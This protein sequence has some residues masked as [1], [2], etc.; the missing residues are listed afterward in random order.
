MV[1]RKQ[2][3]FT[4]MLIFDDSK[5][6]SAIP[7]FEE[8]AGRNAI[9]T[10]SSLDERKLE[11]THFAPGVEPRTPSTVSGYI[12]CYNLLAYSCKHR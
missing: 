2:S 12:A 8:E 7:K 5:R 1:H 11:Y 6:G 10:E 9:K 4:W 3:I